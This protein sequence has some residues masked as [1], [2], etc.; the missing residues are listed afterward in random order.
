[1]VGNKI[2]LL[3]IQGENSNRAVKE[4]ELQNLCKRENL[5]YFEAS[6]K[7]GENIH[8]IFQKLGQK[9]PYPQKCTRQNSNHDLTI[10]DDQ[11]IDLEATTVEGTRETGTCNC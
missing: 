4:A 8:E 7:T 2:D 9:I 6:A 3:N 1:M 5:L 10:T 11:R